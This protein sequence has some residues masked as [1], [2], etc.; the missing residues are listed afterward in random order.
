MR[1]VLA[2]TI[3]TVSA[4]AAQATED[5]YGP[6]RDRSRAASGQGVAAPYTG[7]MLT[8]TGKT[9]APMAASAAP[10]MPQAVAPWAGPVAAVTGQRAAPY[11]SMAAQAPIATDYGP[12]PQIGQPNLPNSLYDRPAVPP[13]AAAPS[14]PTPRYEPPVSLQ[15]AA[16]AGQRAAPYPSTSAQVPIAAYGTVPEAAPKPALST[17]LYGRPAAAPAAVAPTAPAPRYEP[18]ARP[19]AAAPAGQRAAPYP[20]M[21]AQAPTAAALGPDPQVSPKPAPPT[22]LN[23][24]PAA[25]PVAA[26]TP[27]RPQAAAAPAPSAP[28]PVRAPAAPGRSKA[29][30]VLREF[31]GVPDPI[32]IPPPT[33]YWATRADTA[34]VDA[35]EVSLAPDGGVGSEEVDG[36]TGEDEASEAARRRER[37]WNR[38]RAAEARR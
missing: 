29:Y 36:A 10:A 14:A 20:S 30:S 2:I 11:P 28:K 24:R 5:R 21:S 9:P 18:P 12:A 23:D 31:G 22:S 34:P 1:F 26:A 35:V 38:A 4:T 3:L 13:M 33:S 37:D 7:P 15:A 17:S 27:A 16:P 8:W 32:D 25:A 6:T 19:Q